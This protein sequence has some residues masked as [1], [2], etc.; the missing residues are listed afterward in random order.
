[1]FCP[2]CG[3]EVKDNA[4]FCPKCGAN[5]NES[6]QVNSVNNSVDVKNESKGILSFLDDW[7]EWSTGKK[8]ISIIL[9]C[10]IGLIIIGAIGGFLFPDLN[11]SE[12][13]FYMTNS[14]FVIP[15]GCT[16]REGGENAGAAILVR[17]DG[18]EVFVF[19]YYPPTFDS[20]EFIDSNE[21]FDVDGVTVNKIKYH[22]SDGLSFTDYYFNKDNIDYCVVFNQETQPDD[23]LVSSIVKT[24]DTT[25]GSLND[26]ENVYPNSSSS[27]NNNNG[28]E[29]LYDSYTGSSSSKSN[30]NSNSG[31][32][33]TNDNLGDSDVQVRITCNGGWSGSIGVGTSSSTYSGKG[34][35]IINLDGSSSDIVSAVIQK[36][37]SG[38]GKLKVEIIKNGNVKKEASTTSGY[39]VVSVAD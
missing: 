22:Y 18:S 28:H 21:T 27:S 14:S 12:H 6:E 17:D 9:V 11:T 16:I 33:N 26:H 35:K 34:D 13:R 1:M 30:A 36:E 31:S 38:N 7:K 20:S 32:S 15:D 29:D 5:V 3:A 24:M 8:V 25:H 19:D 4:K 2:E 23:N 37:G 39:G 10:C